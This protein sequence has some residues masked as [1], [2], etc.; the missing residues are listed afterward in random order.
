MALVVGAIGILGI[1]VFL[2][3]EQRQLLA[4]AETAD[5]DPLHEIRGSSRSPKGR[6]A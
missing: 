4:E 3:R 1:I 5:T 6:T 2:V